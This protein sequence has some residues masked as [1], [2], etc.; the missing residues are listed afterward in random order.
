M[1]RPFGIGCGIF[2]R[3]AVIFAVSADICHILFRDAAGSK[4]V[5]AGGD[6]GKTIHREA[7]EHI[8]EG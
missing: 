8:G 3:C 6:A 7:V 2:R 4:H 1:L 5:R